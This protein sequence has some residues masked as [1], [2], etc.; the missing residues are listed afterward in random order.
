MYELSKYQ[1]YIASRPADI[2]SSH[3]A[4]YTDSH[5]GHIVYLP[6]ADI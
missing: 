3:V 5:A 2:N 4:V 6:L 1:M